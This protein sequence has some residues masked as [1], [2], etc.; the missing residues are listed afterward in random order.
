MT[1]IASLPHHATHLN[2]V[3]FPFESEES[4]APLLPSIPGTNGACPLRALNIHSE[5]FYCNTYIR[6]MVKSA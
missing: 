1:V 6:C 4:K 3:S 2:V 5:A